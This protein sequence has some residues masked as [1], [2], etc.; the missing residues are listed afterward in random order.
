MLVTMADHSEHAAGGELK[1]LPRKAS[2]R[3]RVQL[4]EGSSSI[5]Q[6]YPCTEGAAPGFA[7]PPQAQAGHAVLKL[8][9]TTQYRSKGC[10]VA[11]AGVHVGAPCRHALPAALAP[12]FA[13]HICLDCTDSLLCLCQM[14]GSGVDVLCWRIS[15]RMCR[16]FLASSSP[17][18]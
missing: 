11:P 15:T 14:G 12:R 13:R 2:K 8:H 3:R 7:T 6:P 17:S 5:L 16:T 1:P 18:C 4:L 9:M 10:F